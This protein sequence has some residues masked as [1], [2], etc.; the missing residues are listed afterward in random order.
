MANTQKAVITA[1]EAVISVCELKYNSSLSKSKSSAIVRR[2]TA[3]MVNG[4]R[5]AR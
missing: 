3:A 2:V 1:T 5:C 4:R